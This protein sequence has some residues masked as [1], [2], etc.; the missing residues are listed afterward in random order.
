MPPVSS[1]TTIT[2]TPR[3]I[4]GLQRRRIE[5]RS[6]AAARVAGSRTDRGCAAGR[7]VPARAARAP[8][9]RTTCG[10]PTAPSSTAA[11]ERQ[12]SIVRGGSGDPEASIAAP[13]T[14]ASTNSNSRPSCRPSASSTRTASAVTSGPMPSPPSTA[15]RCVMRARLLVRGDALALRQ[16][17]AE[18]VDAVEQ[19]VAREGVDRERRRCCHRAASSERRSRSISSSAPGLREQRVHAS[20][21]STITGTSPFLRL[22]LRKMSAISVETTALMPK[23]S[24]AHGACSRD[25]PQPMLR[26]ATRISQPRAAG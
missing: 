18:L 8:P 5:H 15:M 20:A 19:A 13:P 4:S 10:P 1:R 12:A 2:S 22:L 16:Q 11:L 24:S 3:M 17:E 6:R 7:A 9:D 14:S 21:S 23:S 25:D 26:P